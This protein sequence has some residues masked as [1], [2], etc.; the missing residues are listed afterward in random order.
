M[1]HSNMKGWFIFRCR[2]VCMDQSGAGSAATLIKSKGE[3]VP[4]N[5]VVQWLHASGSCTAAEYSL[6]QALTARV[7]NGCGEETSSI[8]S[9]RHCAAQ[10]QLPRTVVA[11]PASRPAHSVASALQNCKCSKGEDHASYYYSRSSSPHH[12]RH[13]ELVYCTA[14]RPCM[15]VHACSANAA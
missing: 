4:I 2:G 9:E 7:L 12:R 1:P 3:E 8:L 6:Q 15:H 5:E 14:H 10:P 13:K 11:Q